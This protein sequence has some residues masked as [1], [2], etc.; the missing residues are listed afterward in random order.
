[1]HL[2]TEGVWLEADLGRPRRVL[3][4]APYRPGFV[5]ARRIIWR[6]VRNADLTADFDVDAWLRAELAATGR[7]D[8]VAMLTSRQLARFVTATAGPVTCA[9][10]V[11]L[12][13]AERVGHRRLV[14]AGHGT[15]NIAVLVDLGLSDTAMIEALTIIAE[16]RTAA[17]MDAGLPL[18]TGRA[19]GTGTDCIALAADPGDL[20]HAGLHTE[21][22]EGLGRAVYAAV[23]DGAQDWLREQAQA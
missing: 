16:A 22:G 5:T 17:V 9:A 15:I 11:G 19:T 10:T 2:T 8:C 21:L 20:R 12:G 14:R 4:F 13:N 1:M 18:P 23:L 6:E 7:E 3:S